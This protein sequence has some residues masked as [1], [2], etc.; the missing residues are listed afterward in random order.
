MLRSTWL[1]TLTIPLALTLAACS[2]GGSGSSSMGS[3]STGT[4]VFEVTDAPLDPELIARVVVEIDAVRVHREADGD[5]GFLTIY[6]GD[7]ISFNLLNLRNGLTQVL[8]RGNLPTGSYG[9]VRVHISDAE[10]ELTD[11][12]V[13][14]TE[15]D[16]IRLTSQDT[17][18]YKLFLSPPVDVRENVE[19][20]VLLD[21][22]T[23]K[24]FSPVP[25]NDLDDARFFHLHPVMRFAVLEETGE[26]RGAVTTTDALGASIPAANAAVYVL[27]PGETD[28]DL[29]L[30]LTM[31]DANGQA[32]ILGVPVGTYDVLATLDGRTGRDE[33]LVVNVGAV[34]SFEIALE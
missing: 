22:L 25:A 30:A 15:D 24:T 33:G 19:T 20:R 34:T 8:S 6:E 17:S 27:A 23:S 14:S 2:G 5:S 28:P 4:I 11:G 1:C 12:R 21:F 29:A 26:L 3:S 16:T 9:Q 31:T 10:L 32:A 18:G 7:P 13:F